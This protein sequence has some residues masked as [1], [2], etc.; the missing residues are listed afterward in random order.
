MGGEL[1][2]CIP[3]A[4]RQQN[5]ESFEEVRMAEYV[6]AYQRNGGRPPPCPELPTDPGAR[7]AIGLPPILVPF[8]APSEPLPEIHFWETTKNDGEYLQSIVA[9]SKYA[10][11]SPEELR[12]I[13]YAN[14]NKDLPVK[15]S[16]DWQPSVFQA[17]R[18][19]A[20]PVPPSAL[21]EK[22][23]Y[24]FEERRV[25]FMYAGREL[26]DSEIRNL[27]AT[28]PMKAYQLSTP[29]TSEAAK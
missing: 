1:F 12:C 15:I 7:E 6:K 29:A 26:E 18:P 13:A 3:Q 23:K 22:D 10:D 11:Y 21:S 8:K 14:G 17:L 16:I 2:A 4:V 19:P 27:H 5:E 25:A 24:S 20:A 9:A 28:N